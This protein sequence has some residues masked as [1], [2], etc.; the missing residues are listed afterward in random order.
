MVTAM[1]G[2][3][4][5]FDFA[6]N[7]DL[8]PEVPSRAHP[9]LPRWVESA[10]DDAAARQEVCCAL[11]TCFAT[12]LRNFVPL[13]LRLTVCPWKPPDLSVA[14]TLGA[15][16]FAPPEAVRF[17]DDPNLRPSSFSFTFTPGTDFAIFFRVA[18][19]RTMRTFVKRL[20]FDFSV[21]EPRPTRFLPTSTSTRQ[22]RRL[23]VSARQPIVI[24]RFTSRSGL[25]TIAVSGFF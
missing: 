21:F 8:R 13:P 24:P 19:F 3:P 15:T 9:A 10:C 5:T 14:T 1:L 18:L 12:P 17:F 6:A 16:T 7:F 4:P 2:L 22:L 25:S 23:A 20:P 11:P